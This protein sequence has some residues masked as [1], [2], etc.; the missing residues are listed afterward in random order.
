MFSVPGLT[1]RNTGIYPH[2]FSSGHTKSAV[3][4]AE[5]KSTSNKPDAEKDSEQSES[6]INYGEGLAPESKPFQEPTQSHHLQ[7]I[8]SQKRPFEQLMRKVPI[9][10]K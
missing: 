8:Q 5:G 2:R 3:C 9:Q 7:S 6:M 10:M 4:A 1:H